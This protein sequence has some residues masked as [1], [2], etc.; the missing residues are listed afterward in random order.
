MVVFAAVLTF[1]GTELRAHVEVE[2]PVSLTAPGIRPLLKLDH[3]GV[4]CKG[5]VVL[6]PHAYKVKRL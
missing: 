4:S 6:V 2:L 3:Q 1:K 5:E